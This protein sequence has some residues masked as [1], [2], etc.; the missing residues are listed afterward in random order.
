MRVSGCQRDW[1][2]RLVDADRESAHK[3][4][5]DAKKLQI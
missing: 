4:R 1:G 3:E 2:K 5:C